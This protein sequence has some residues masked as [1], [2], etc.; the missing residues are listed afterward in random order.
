VRGLR[1]RV[2][3]EW[4]GRNYPAPYKE[5]APETL[6]VIG[7]ADIY[8]QKMP[9]T[10]FCVFSPAEAFS[11]DFEEMSLFAG[12]AVGQTNELLG[13]EEIVN[14]MMADAAAIITGRLA[15]MTAD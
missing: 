14:E 4:E 1:N 15:A 8:G 6:P 11:G 9:M 10:R 7:E 13:A 2:V 12:E 3:K 5:H